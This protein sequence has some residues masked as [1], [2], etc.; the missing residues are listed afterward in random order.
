MKAIRLLFLLS[1]LL[2]LSAVLLRQV[3]LERLAPILLAR[4]GLLQVNLE[5]SQVDHQH[6]GVRSLAFALPNPDGPIPIRVSDALCRYQASELL[7]GKISSC[8]AGKVEIFLPQGKTA[9]NA[10]RQSDLP[11]LDKLLH[12]LD[13]SRIPLRELELRQLQ[14]HYAAAGPGNPS[15]FSLK[16]LN[17]PERQRLLLCSTESASAP[18]LQVQLLKRTIPSP[19]RW[20][21]IWPVFEASF[22]RR[23]R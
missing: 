12:L 2:F 21:L 17:E 11:E 5:L 6:L 4:A 9:K 19:P 14:V 10:K 15:I 3:G 16:V 18:A 22:P 7:H 1:L 8:S 23:R 20:L 13:P